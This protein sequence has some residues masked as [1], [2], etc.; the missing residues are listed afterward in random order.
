M[1]MSRNTRKALGLAALIAL[2][3]PLRV[4]AQATNTA[5]SEQKPPQQKNALLYE[6][7]PQNDE[8]QHTAALEEIA[9]RNDKSYNEC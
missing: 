1:T 3:A 7:L 5:A 2:V 9:Q 6:L 8:E 4:G